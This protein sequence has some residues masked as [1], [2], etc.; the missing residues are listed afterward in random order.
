MKAVVFILFTWHD[1]EKIWLLQIDLE[2]RER[3]MRYYS[4]D[5]TKV[6]C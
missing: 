5:K 1:V 2:E 4:A 3:G 6:E